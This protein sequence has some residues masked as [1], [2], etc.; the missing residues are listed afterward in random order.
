MSSHWR[1]TTWLTAGLLACLIVPLF[2]FLLA[3]GAIP[4]LA[5]GVGSCDLPGYHVRV[6]KRPVSSP[7][8]WADQRFPMDSLGARVARIAKLL[9]SVAETAKAIALLDGHMQQLP[10]EPFFE[11]LSVTLV[12]KSKGHDPLSGTRRLLRVGPEDLTSWTRHIAFGVR[13]RMRTLEE[14]IV[15]HLECGHTLPAMVLLRSHL[16]AAALA[17]HC[18][19]ELSAA[20]RQDAMA[21]LRVLIP[22]TLFG[23]SLKRHRQK[24]SKA[25]LL[26]AFEGDTIRICEAVESLD[27]FYY[28]EDADGRL[29]LAYSL[30][31][32]YAHP[33]H[34]G[35]MD[36]MVATERPGG[37]EI[38]Y[39]PEA[40]P[41]SQLVVSAMET[42]LVTMRAGY[43]AT[44]LLLCWQ[45]ATANGELVWR[46]PSPDQ[47]RRVWLD[48]LQRATA[49]AAEH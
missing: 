20:A 11:P 13:C 34:R 48:L 8:C 5:A 36:F 24:V 39:R 1:I 18:L 9:P 30:L 44:Q 45:F 29:A 16:E 46:G 27:K 17:A 3:Q 49:E 28:L 4:Q 43:A 6:V 23:T 14:P 47:G 40:A 2:A 32:E 31:C 37:W 15:R 12:S 10:A 7:G 22:K 41:H 19:Q 35:V 26:K 33:N 25:A 21:S 42:L 38:T